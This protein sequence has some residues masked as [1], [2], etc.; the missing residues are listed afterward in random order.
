MKALNYA[1]MICFAFILSFL[2]P[3]AYGVATKRASESTNINFSAVS[4]EFLRSTSERNPPKQTYERL[5][6]GKIISEEE[7]LYSLPFKNFL[8]LIAKNKFPPSLSYFASDV[9]LIRSNSQSL[10]ISKGD[11]LK[12]QAPLY[13]LL[14]STPR[15]L[16]LEM[17]QHIIS[18]RDGVTFIDM[19][20]NQKDENLSL[21]FKNTLEKS[22]LKFPIKELFSNPTTLKPFDEGA[23]LVDNQDRVFHLKIVDSKPVVHDTHIQKRDILKIIV[24]ENSRKEFYGALIGLD[25]VFL[26]SYDNYSLLKMPVSTYN[27]LTD[28]FA[29]NIDP[30]FKTATY[31]SAEKIDS[32]VMNPD[33]SI[34]KTNSFTKH[35]D[36]LFED[37]KEY[38]FTYETKLDVRDF[39]LKFDIEN[40]S[41]KA[42][43]LGLFFIIFYFIIYKKRDAFDIALLLF[44]GIYGF[45]SLI[46]FKR[47]AL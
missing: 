6:D 16:Q 43:I 22:G 7:Y 21:E 38:I 13:L 15:L 8:Y 4:E 19:N 35:K 28:N 46:L 40:I 26:I 27:P 14:E 44:R 20:T 18:L 39:T 34:Y 11:I 42:L 41:Y 45:I 37:V 29:L 3:Y 32:F 36:T 30:L 2:L 31:K 5:S 9:S 24:N 33:Y 12:N 23:F 1:L 25:G 10:N 47:K 17:P